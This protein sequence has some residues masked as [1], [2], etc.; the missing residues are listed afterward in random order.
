M[1]PVSQID[2]INCLQPGIRTPAML[3]QGQF[4]TRL[5]ERVLN[6]IQIDA[7]IFSEPIGGNDRPLTSPKM[8]EELVLKS[9]SPILKALNRRKVHTIIFRTY[10]N[11]KILIPSILKWGFNCL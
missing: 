9:Y 1:G 11:T 5:V 6:E 8:Y 2:A 3:I 4:S 7:A 10:A